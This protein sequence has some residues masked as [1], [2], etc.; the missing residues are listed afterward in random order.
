MNKILLLIMLFASQLNAQEL[1]ENNQPIK[2]AMGDIGSIKSSLNDNST[3]QASTK[4]WA[5]LSEDQRKVLSPLGAEWDTLR[6]WQREK[7]LDIAKDY[8]KM[9]AEKQQRVQKR[10]NSWSRMTPYERENARKRYQQFHALSADKKDEVRKKWADYQK[11]SEAERTKLRK[12]SPELDYD[13]EF[14]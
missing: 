9:D 5:Q 14:D 1:M 7:M 3:S 2:L 10:L 4:S 13:P 11:L 8:P 6:P 12:E